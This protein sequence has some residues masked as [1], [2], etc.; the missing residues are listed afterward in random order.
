MSCTSETERAREGESGLAVV[1]H[2]E[3]KRLLV[4]FVCYFFT[5]RLNVA[6]KGDQKMTGE[7]LIGM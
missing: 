6:V 7:C 5:G 1:G 3:L 2:F 4:F